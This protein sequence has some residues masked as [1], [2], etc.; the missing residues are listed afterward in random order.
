MLMKHAITAT[1]GTQQSASLTAGTANILKAVYK[2]V[3]GGAEQQSTLDTVDSSVANDPQITAVDHCA[4]LTATD[5]STNITAPINA[6]TST[7]ESVSLSNDGTW[8]GDSFETF[9]F[10]DVVPEPAAMYM[11][12]RDTHTYKVRG[13]TYMKDR[14]KV[15][16]S[17]GIGRVI[18]MEIFA[19]DH[20]RFGDR[21]DHVAAI[22][23]AKKRVDIMKRLPDKPLVFVFNIQVPGDPPVSLVYYFLIPYFY[24]TGEGCPPELKKAS[25]LFKRFIDI[26]Y[27]VLPITEEHGEGQVQG[28]GRS[29]FYTEPAPKVWGSDIVWPQPGPDNPGVLPSTSFQNQ[30]FKLIPFMVEAPWVVK[31]AVR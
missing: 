9:E 12:I 27:S 21:Y 20:S 25:D 3:A 1:T 28:Q 14:K 16:A 24:Y 17:R 4:T 22:G 5:N 10:L 8:R 19:V 11:N 7:G 30:R 18:T 29:P 13:E 2:T 23:I 6:S 26:P 31:M 15:S